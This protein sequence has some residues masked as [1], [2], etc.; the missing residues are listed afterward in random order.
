MGCLVGNH[1]AYHKRKH[2]ETGLEIRSRYHVHSA[3]PADLVAADDLAYAGDANR[4][5]WSDL[6]PAG[7]RR[8]WRKA[9]LNLEIQNDAGEC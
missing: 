3:R 2:F 1:D 7:A 9:F 4:F 8:S 6:L 5:A